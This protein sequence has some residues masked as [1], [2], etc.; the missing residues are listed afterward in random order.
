M[1]LGAL[2]PPPSPVPTT[3]H[4]HRVQT[5]LE[6]P[7][8][9]LCWASSLQGRH[10]RGQAQDGR[11]YRVQGT[12]AVL[13]QTDY[14][15]RRGRVLSTHGGERAGGGQDSPRGQACVCLGACTRIRVNR[16]DAGNGLQAVWWRPHPRS[17]R[18]PLERA[19][20]SAK[21]GASDPGSR[22]LWSPQ[23]LP[24]AC[25][26]EAARGPQCSGAPSCHS[27]A[28]SYHSGAPSCYSGA[29]S[30][31]AGRCSLLLQQCSLLSHRCSLLSQQCSLLAR[32]PPGSETLGVAL[33]LSPP[34]PGAVSRKRKSKGVGALICHRPQSPTL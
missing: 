15:P 12:E 11:S 20:A 31:L 7:L 13:G 29:P 19:E 10:L 14:R 8:S 5:S 4:P 23:Q 28:P 34:P 3:H 21:A 9:T 17:A 30:W 24:P 22:D 16:P 1:T 32:R 18:S 27:G 26:A 2:G 6:G 33:P 25:G